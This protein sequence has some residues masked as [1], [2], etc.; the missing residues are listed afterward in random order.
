M[1][2]ED[3]IMTIENKDMRNFARELVRTI[4]PYFFEVPA[5][6]TGKYHPMYALGVGGLYRHT[7]AVVKFVNYFFEVDCFKNRWD[8]RGR[9]IMRIAAIMHDSFKSGTQ[10]EYEASKYTRHD[11]PL[12]AAQN[13]LKKIGCGTIPDDEIKAIASA[14]STHMGQWSTSPRSAT[15][16]PEPKDK[17]QQMLH[18][19]DY[20]ASRKDIEVL[21]LKQDGN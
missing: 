11:H 15:V 14:V 13:I 20:L 19:A 17:T 8:S 6:S 4:P 3:A 2:F 21:F 18:L 5:S 12:I 1:A 9:D 7:L 16:L 10:N